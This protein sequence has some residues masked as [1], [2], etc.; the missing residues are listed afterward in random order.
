MSDPVVYSSMVPAKDGFYVALE[1]NTPTQNLV[2]DVR[3]YGVIGNGV[4]ND[5]VAI[6]AA[7]DAVP[8]TGGTVYIAAGLVCP[9]S[10]TFT[11]KSKTRM[12][13]GGKFVALP[14]GSWSVA[15]YPFLKNVNFNSLTI[16]D[17]D[18]TFDNL[19]VD[20]SAIYSPGTAHII[21][22]RKVRTVRV[23]NCT[24]IGGA[25]QTALLGC[26][27][28]LVS[29]NR[30]LN[31]TNCGADHW[32]GPTNA[33]VIGNYIE[34][35][36]TAQMVNFNP[37]PTTPPSTGY[38]ASGF[39]MSGNIIVATGASAEPCQIEPLRAGAYVAGVTIEGNYFKNSHLVIRGDVRGFSIVG[40]TFQDIQ[41][42]AEVITNYVFNGGVGSGIVIS[43]NTIL[44]PNTGAPNVSVIR[45]ETDSATISNNVVMGTAYTAQP[46]Y[47]A[48]YTPNQYGNWFEKLGVTGRLQQGFLLSNPNNATDNPRA[49]YGWTDL[50]G[51][52]LRM[53]MTGNFHEFHSTTAAGALRQVW[54]MQANNDTSHWNIL[55]PL[56]LS[57]GVL[58]V[59]PQNNIT[60]A[61]ATPGTATNLTQN[62][63]AVT[64]VAAGTG[65][66]L[67]TASAQSV[68]G[69]LVVVFN[70]GANTLNVY[71]PAG[72]Q[73]NALGVDV[74]NTIASG[75]SAAY[76][77]I[78][79]TQYYTW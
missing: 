41:G 52:A 16:L 2:I 56:L 5:S 62:F 64:T 19:T 59:S 78:T 3:N 51:D 53:Y 10:Q 43:G 14:V 79:N 29:G 76:F 17:T 20:Y 54:S 49:C 27:D 25:S 60:A 9:F 71:P 40:N 28:T 58:R 8:S 75:A 22:L 77:A 63:N 23:E 13:G 31:S 74:A 15:Q 57:S 47:S 38:S 18:I 50:D 70:R 36:N 21:H 24:F 35:N 11:V 61:G 45:C 1:P 68:N 6:Q 42:S 67:P 73:I 44:N 66:R 32:D 48:S 72:G 12:T 33:R 69:M 39:T 30:M 55:V 46:F 34:A 4:A 7:L 26:D 37:D 65:V